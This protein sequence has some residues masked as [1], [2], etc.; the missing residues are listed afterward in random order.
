MYCILAFNNKVNHIVPGGTVCLGAFVRFI[1]NV[2]L[3]LAVH[4]NHGNGVLILFYNLAN[5]LYNI[6]HR[7]LPFFWVKGM[8]GCNI[9][10]I[11][12]IVMYGKVDMRKNCDAYT[13]IK[14]FSDLQICFKVI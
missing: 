6:I 9:V 13:D 8:L 2:A 4:L 14:L 1:V 3:R 12:A 11:L 7:A 10:I 5:R